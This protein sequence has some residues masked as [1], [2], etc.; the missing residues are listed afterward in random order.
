MRLIFFLHKKREENSNGNKLFCLNNNLPLDVGD[1]VDLKVSRVST[2]GELLLGSNDNRVG[3]GGKGDRGG[4]VLGGE[5]LTVPDVTSLDD[6]TILEVLL[7]TS[8]TVGGAVGGGE[9]TLEGVLIIIDASA[10]I[11][12]VRAEAVQD[13]GGLLVE[14]PGLAG[15]DGK[16]RTT[17]NLGELRVTA[18]DIH[19]GN[20]GD[21]SLKTGVG[22][23]DSNRA[24]GGGGGNDVSGVDGELLGITS[25]GLGKG[26]GNGGRLAGGDLNLALG[27]GDGGK[28]LLKL[29]GGVGVTLA[30]VVRV[31]GLGR[32]VRDGVGLG[33]LTKVL[34]GDLLGLAEVDSVQEID[35]VGGDGGGDRQGVHDVNETSTLLGNRDQVLALPGLG[36]GGSVLEDLA[37]L[38]TTGT[39]LLALVEKS[40]GAGDVGGRHRGTRKDGVSILGERVG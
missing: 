14:V 26:Q 6:L 9:V 1:G 10:E 11:G 13:D 22:D 7:A 2:L 27:E 24:L 15:R 16:N 35:V 8:E 33:L 31:Q 28:V 20:L 32:G 12:R 18:L 25:L 39:V 4:R 40:L 30:V 19:H 29:D 3:A 36:E 5:D 34:D 37:G 23:M 21:I 17:D 38:K